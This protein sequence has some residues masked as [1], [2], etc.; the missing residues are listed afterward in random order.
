LSIAAA[1]TYA[2]ARIASVCAHRHQ[3]A[4]DVG[5]LDDLAPAALLSTPTGLP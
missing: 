1:V 5:V 2:T 3:H 4:A